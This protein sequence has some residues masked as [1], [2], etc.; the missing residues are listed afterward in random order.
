MTPQE[1]IEAAELAEAETAYRLRFGRRVPAY[2]PQTARD[3]GIPSLETLGPLP[4]T[5][6]ALNGHGGKPGQPA[7]VGADE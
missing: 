6:V 4:E 2:V 3:F 7:E 5:P 1:A